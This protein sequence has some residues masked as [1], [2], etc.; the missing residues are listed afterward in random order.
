MVLCWTRLTDISRY[1]NKTYG[2][3]K[4]IELLLRLLSALKEKNFIQGFQPKK[5]SFRF[6]GFELILLLFTVVT[7]L[8]GFHLQ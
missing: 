5:T 2:F 1:L 7:S 8:R 3:L 4:T 6:H